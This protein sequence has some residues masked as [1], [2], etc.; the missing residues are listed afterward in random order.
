MHFSSDQFIKSF[1]NTSSDELLDRLATDGLTEAATNAIYFLLAERGIANADIA[2]L[3]QNAKKD[4]FRKTSVTNECA[5][6]GNSPDL[7]PCSIK[8]KNFAVVIA[9]L[10]IGYWK[11]H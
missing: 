11:R 6:C 5:Y 9:C 10:K 4:V 3:V 7:I 2:G 1:R 8:A